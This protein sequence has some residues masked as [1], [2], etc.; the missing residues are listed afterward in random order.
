[1]RLRNKKE[2]PKK[3]IQGKLFRNKPRY[4]DEAVTQQKNCKGVILPFPTHTGRIF[5]FTRIRN[6]E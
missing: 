4:S 6:G 3:R 5:T 2:V 1:L